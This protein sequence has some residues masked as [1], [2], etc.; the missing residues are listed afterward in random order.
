MR[1][2]DWERLC[3]GTRENT[4]GSLTHKQQINMYNAKAQNIG[5]Y[6]QA[7]M[8]GACATQHGGHS[9]H[10]QMTIQLICIL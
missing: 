4:T 3:G 5:I 10:G 2:E 6:I 8:P 1:T 7:C 9:M